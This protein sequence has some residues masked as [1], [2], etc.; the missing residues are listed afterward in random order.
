MPTRILKNDFNHYVKILEERYYNK[1]ICDYNI[2]TLIL[3]CSMK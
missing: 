2:Q 1:T 3:L